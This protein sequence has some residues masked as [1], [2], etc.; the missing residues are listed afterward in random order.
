LDGP[1]PNRPS[2]GLISAG[3]VIFGTSVTLHVLS[4]VCG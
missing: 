4:L 3:I 2:T 1:E